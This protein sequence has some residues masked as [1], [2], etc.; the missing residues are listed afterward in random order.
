[1]SGNYAAHI[2]RNKNE[3]VT[4]NSFA[5]IAYAVSNKY[6]GGQ[7]RLEGY[8]KTSNLESGR[9]ALLLRLDKKGK[10][11]A[12]DNME[13]TTIDGTRDWK[14]YSISLPLHKET[15]TIFVG[16]VISGTGEAW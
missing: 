14:K 5:V 15:E 2:F 7:V 16:G 13:E 12:A 6:S 3:E 10:V 8:I 1:Y 9:A 11:L 4:A